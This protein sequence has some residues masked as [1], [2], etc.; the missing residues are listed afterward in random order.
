MLMLKKCDQVTNIADLYKFVNI[1]PMRLHAILEKDLPFAQI[2]EW[3]MSLTT[4]NCLFIL[5]FHI[6]Y[7][8]VDLEQNCQC[9]GYLFKWKERHSSQH[10]MSLN[11]D[12]LKGW[13]VKCSSITA[14]CRFSKILSVYNQYSAFQTLLHILHKFRITLNLDLDL[15]LDHDLVIDLNI[16]LGL[17]LDLDPEIWC[18]P[19]T[20][21]YIFLFIDLTLSLKIIQN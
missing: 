17:E 4:Y 10:N 15:D 3:R 5:L 6:I 1:T 13:I 20:W 14:K 2:W 19:R 9:H 12:E 16:Y 21:P 18:W 11:P 7:T 8:H